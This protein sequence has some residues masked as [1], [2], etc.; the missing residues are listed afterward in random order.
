MFR[1]VFFAAILAGVAAGL[2]VSALQAVKLTP[3]IAAAE[4][5]ET[6][7]HRAAGWEPAPGFERAAVTLAANTVIGI[8]FGLLLSAGIALHQVFA[9]A[10]ADARRGLLWGLAGF[11]CFSLAPALGLPPELPGSAAAGLLARQGWWI[12]TALATAAGIGLMVFGRPPLWRVLGGALIALPHLWGAPT[13]PSEGSAVP[14]SLAA[15]FAAVSLA[16]AALFWIVLGGVGG[17]L[18]ARLGRT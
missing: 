17:W 15:E 5:Y 13:A 16:T 2:A 10:E 1:R 8:G 4:V 11:A 9:G 12:G 6:G 7:A 3:L 14:A 18:Y